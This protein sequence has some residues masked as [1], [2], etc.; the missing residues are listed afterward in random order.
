MPRQ[1][2]TNWWKRAFIGLL[3]GA[4]SLALV[5]LVNAHGGDPTKIHS[6][7]RT[8]NGDL[9]IVAPQDTCGPNTSPLDWNQQGSQGPPGPTGPAGAAG[10]SGWEIVRV[11]STVPNVAAGT[12]IEAQAACPAGKKVLGGG[13]V[14]QGSQSPVHAIGSDPFDFGSLSG[15]NVRFRNSGGPQPTVELNV[16]AVCANVGT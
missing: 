3:A 13:G 14:A 16:Y 1:S 6:C 5:T 2:A 10:V 7:V 15:F 11:Q 4:A 9:R 8:G 12:V